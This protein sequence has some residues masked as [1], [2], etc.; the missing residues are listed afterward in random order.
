MLKEIKIDLQ[1]AMFSLAESSVYFQT[2]LKQITRKL[3]RL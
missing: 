1:D 3:L 2:F